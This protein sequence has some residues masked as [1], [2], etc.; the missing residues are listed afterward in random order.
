MHKK[1]KVT[2]DH[3]VSFIIPTYNDGATIEPCLK[4]IKENYDSN[5]CEIII[6]ND[7]SSDNTKEILERLKITYAL[8]I[9][10]NSENCG[11][12]K[13]LN[14]A[15]DFAKYPILFFID[16]DT[17]VNKEAITDILARFDD[18]PKVGGV[19][20][21]YKVANKHNFLTRMQEVEYIVL[22]FAQCAYNP[23]STVSLW[24]G[25]MAFRKQAF[26]DIGK[27][28]EN[29]ITE[30][31]DAALKLKERG[32]K[33]EQS[34]APVKTDV[35]DTLKVWWKQKQR[36]SMG[37]AQC[38]M[39]HFKCYFSNPL[40]VVMEVSYVAITFLFIANIFGNHKVLTDLFYIYGTLIRTGI[41]LIISVKE[42][43]LFYVPE[44]IKNVV[45]LITYP[46]LSVTPLFFDGE[47]KKPKNALLIY[48]FALLYMPFLTVAGTIG[49]I[50]GIGKWVQLRRGGRGW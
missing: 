46:L 48:P 32:W 29:C 26:Q 31:M 42:L 10:H 44:I 37:F 45:G 14:Y 5:K 23:Y 33:A 17:I 1:R 19:S 2:S 15:S 38:F 39:S 30:D 12:A 4:S 49:Y 40:A 11:K 28:S 34:F 41:S 21:R 24:G 22:S 8:N 9:I 18:N 43:V 27:L 47:Y 25:F 50:R 3:H 16:S 13:S 36:W 6:V 35:P 7:C 20:C